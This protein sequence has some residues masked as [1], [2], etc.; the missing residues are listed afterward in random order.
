MTVISITFIIM[1]AINGAT[2]VKIIMF[3]KVSLK[4][5]RLWNSYNFPVKSKRRPRNQEKDPK[6]R[7]LIPPNW[8]PRFSLSNW[9]LIYDEI[10]STQRGTCLDLYQWNFC[11][12]MSSFDWWVSS[13]DIILP[14]F[15][16]KYP[17]NNFFSSN[18]HF[19][20]SDLLLTHSSRP[21][22]HFVHSTFLLTFV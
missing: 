2:L 7:V 22:A 12:G 4:N 18:R 3:Y 15:P 20:E 6:K 17:K 16:S 9:S 19:R 8:S 5:D 21:R 13:H 11:L 10:Q 14:F 1:T